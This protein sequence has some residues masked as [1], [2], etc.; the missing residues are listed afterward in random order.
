M[1]CQALTQMCLNCGLSRS[2][3]RN[4]KPMKEDRETRSVLL[5][6][7][8]AMRSGFVGYVLFKMSSR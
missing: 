8:L 3:D 7:R 4:A 1:L 6:A 5:V 2:N